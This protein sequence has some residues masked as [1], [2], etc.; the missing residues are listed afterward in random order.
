MPRK[1]IYTDD[2]ALL[3]QNDLS[4]DLEKIAK[5]WVFATDKLNTHQKW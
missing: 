1:F 3:R 5:L 2:M 4:S